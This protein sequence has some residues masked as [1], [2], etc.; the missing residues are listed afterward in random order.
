LLLVCKNIWLANI[1]G[2]T[3]LMVIFIQGLPGDGPDRAGARKCPQNNLW[4]VVNSARKKLIFFF[5]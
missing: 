3:V 5:K 1:L 2:F 4:G